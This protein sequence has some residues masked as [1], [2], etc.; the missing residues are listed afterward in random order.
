MKILY[1]PASPYSAKVR[2]AAR[3]TGLPVKS[4][5]VKTD[6]EPTLLIANNP[7][8]KIPVLLRDDGSAVFDSRAI[9]QFLDRLSGGKLYPTE[10]EARTR[11]EVL[12]AMAD[13]ITDCLLAHVYERRFRPEE[14]IH[15]PWLDK[16]WSKVAR[17]LAH[18]EANPVSFENG[19]TG[20][21]IAV[22]A[23]AGYLGLR[24]AGQW[25][26]IWPGHRTFLTTFETLFPAY[27]EFRSQ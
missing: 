10:A 9:M 20:G 17:G 4:E 25:E 5:I 13:G 8:G 6:D 21:H 16:Q 26:Q 24:F 7:L 11:A 22:A 23:L 18:L 2:M 12:E 14:K 15:Q 1:S 3:H 19:L 27:P